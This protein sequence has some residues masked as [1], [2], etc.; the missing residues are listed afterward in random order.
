MLAPPRL[1]LTVDLAALAANWRWLAARS[2]PAECA[3]AVKANGYGT[4]M[5][6]AVPALMGAGCQ[7][8][9]VATCQ[10]GRALRKLSDSAR[11]FVLDGVRTE[12]EVDMF[13][14]SRLMPV[15]N[16]A[17]QLS[18]WQS[19]NGPCAIMLETGINRLGFRQA[20]VASINFEH[21]S[22]V[23]TMSHLVSADYPDDPKNQQQLQ[24][25]QAYLMQCPNT[26]ASLANSAAI[27]LGPAYHFQLTRPGIALYGGWAGPPGSEQVRQVIT[28]EASVLQVRN[29]EAGE[30][31]GYNAIWTARRPSRIATLGAGYADGYLRAFS[32]TG[33]VWLGS[34][35]CPVVGRVSMDM[36][37]VDVTDAGPVQEGDYAELIGPHITLKEASQASGLSQYELLTSLGSRYD[38]TYVGDNA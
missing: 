2:H 32:N 18:R 22:I 17:E 35:H 20:D 12:A 4:G 16:S 24:A 38:R 14:S 3:A 8:F 13:A 19:W 11:I 7:T 34:T 23:L 27:L 28:A 9:F 25:F 36:I 30:S 21:M 15:L 37:T 5:E 31:V 6:R 10:E 29:L 33:M 1:R 26:D